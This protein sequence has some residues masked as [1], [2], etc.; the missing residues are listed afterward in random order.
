MATL[1]LGLVGAD[2]NPG[3]RPGTYRSAQHERSDTRE[4]LRDVEVDE[5]VDY[6][7]DARHPREQGDGLPQRE[8]TAT[9]ASNRFRM[10]SQR[11]A[12]ATGAAA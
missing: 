12:L 2:A 5:V 6:R 9:P 4:G 10:A 3:A 8:V 1:P 11:N 7:H